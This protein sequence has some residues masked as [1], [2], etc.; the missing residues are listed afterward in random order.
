MGARWLAC[1]FY[2]QLELDKFWNQRLAV[3]PEGFPLAYEE[4]PGIFVSFMAYCL[5]VSLRAQLRPTHPD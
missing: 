4:L 1:E 5:H 2:R 3:I